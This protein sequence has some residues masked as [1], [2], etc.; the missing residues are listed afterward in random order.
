MIKKNI[1]MHPPQKYPIPWVPMEYR[2]RKMPVGNL[3]PGFLEAE[4]MLLHTIL[5]FLHMARSQSGNIIP[6][7]NATT[8]GNNVLQPQNISRKLKFAFN[9]NP[10]TTRGRWGWLPP[11]HPPSIFQWHLIVLWTAY[12]WN[13]QFRLRFQMSNTCGSGWDD[14]S[15]LIWASCSCSVRWLWSLM[16]AK[17]RSI[18][19]VTT[20][21]ATII[22]AK[23]CGS[24]HD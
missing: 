20:R 9:I 12:K 24:F 5:V 8:A 22:S 10:A 1:Q 11:H 2:C 23:R 14:S 4:P 15:S 17:I 21:R 6:I 19:T 13:C 16:C 3:A 7:D 18:R